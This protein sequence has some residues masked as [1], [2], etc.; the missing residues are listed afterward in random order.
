[1]KIKKFKFL[2]NTYSEEKHREKFKLQFKVFF[3]NMRIKGLIMRESHEHSII[4]ENFI[5]IARHFSF[6]LIY[7]NVRNIIHLHVIVI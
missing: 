5:E 2:S 1:M 7:I 4:Y 6:T 3:F